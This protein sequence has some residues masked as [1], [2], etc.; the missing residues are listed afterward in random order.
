MEHSGTRFRIVSRELKLLLIFTLRFPLSKQV[1][2]YFK[3][4]YKKP[5]ASKIL[6]TIF[7]AGQR[8]PVKFDR[9]TKI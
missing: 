3:D 2:K 9:A 7:E 8:N 6:I 1:L 4:E 5:Y